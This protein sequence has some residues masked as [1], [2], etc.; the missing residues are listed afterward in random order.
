MT[1]DDI[2]RLY[3]TTNVMSNDLS[4]A[5]V[6]YNEREAFYDAGVRLRGSE[7]GRPTSNRVSF[8]IRFPADHLFRGVHRSVGIDRSGGWSGLVPSQSQD[9]ILIKHFAQYAGGVP[10]MYDDLCRVIAPR[11]QHTS[12][13]LLMMAKYGNVY[14]DSTFE[15]GGDGTNFKLELIYHPTTA[16]AQGYKN[17]QPDGVIGSDFRNLGDDKEPY[18]WNFLIKSNRGRDDYSKLIAL[19]KAFSASSA[20]RDAETRAI[21]DIDIWMRTMAVY[22]LGGVND[23]YTYGNNHNLMVHAPAGD[24]KVMA[25]LWDTDFSFTR[26]ATSGLWGDQGLRRIIE[27]PA[28][29]RRY[30]GHLDDIIDKSYNADYMRHWT[31]HYGSITGRNFGGIL[32]YIRTR[33]GFVR[34]RL[35]SAVTFRITTNGGNDLTVNSLA[36][37]LEGEGGI[38]VQDFAVGGSETPL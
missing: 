23:A 9:E 28:N 35:P 34:G 8:N 32:N 17:P 20:T 7:R 14:L 6:V 29:T 21:M 36:V 33:A 19:C 16:N 4:G 2:S 22:S 1:P 10:S 31:E 24:G 13:A 27:I 15:S 3:Q 25:M 38:D 37:T 18:R 11:S 5:T 26:S 30:Y 12:N